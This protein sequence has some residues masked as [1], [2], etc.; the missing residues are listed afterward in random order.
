MGMLAD[1][2]EGAEKELYAMVHEK[3]MDRVKDQICQLVMQ[4]WSLE[5]QSR[6]LKEK[7]RKQQLPR[8][9]EEGEE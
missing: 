8:V 2:L 3:R 7:Q 4:R 5:E 9:Q 1:V 6:E